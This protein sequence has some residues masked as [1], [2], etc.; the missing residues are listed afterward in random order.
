VTFH[1]AM[2]WLPDYP[3]FRDYT[4]R[5][6]TVEDRFKKLGEKYSVAS[7]LKKLGVGKGRKPRPKAN[8]RRWCSPVEDQGELGSCTAHAGIGLLEYYERRVHDRYLDASRRFLYKTTRNL[9]GVRGDTGAQLRTTMGA[10]R[11]F[12][13]PPERYWPYE[14]GRYDEEPSAFCY[15]FAREYQSMQYFRL[16]PWSMTRD[17]VLAAIKETLASGVPSMF[18]FVIYDS[19]TQAEESGRIPFPAPREKRL[20]GHAVVAV[21]Y[22]DGMEITNELGGEATR[23]ALLIR[24]SWGTGWGEKGYGWLPYEYVI[25]GQAIDWWSLLKSEWV[26]TGEFG[27]G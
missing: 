4:V 23:G 14:I 18:G 15:S 25:R 20:G 16:D 7:M 19:Y 9:M 27:E 24:N 22:D 8:Y 17:K 5:T 11:L 6:D 21:G 2:G 10:M 12:G 13:V 1:R 3:D 26:D